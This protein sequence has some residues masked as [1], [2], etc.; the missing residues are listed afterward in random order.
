MGTRGSG[1]AD[2]FHGYAVVEHGA[3]SR[4]AKLARPFRLAAGSLLAASA[5]LA[6]RLVQREPAYPGLTELVRQFH[7]AATGGGPVPITADETLDIAETRDRLMTL[8][9]GSEG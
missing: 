5:N 3:V 8:G 7:R 9:R 6:R 1:R 2:L 4:T